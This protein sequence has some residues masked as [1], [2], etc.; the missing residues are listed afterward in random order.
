MFNIVKKSIEWNGKKIE[1]ETGKIARQASASVIVRMGESTVLCTVTFSKNLKEGIDFFPLSVNYLEKYYAAG[2]FPGGFMKREGK[3]SDRE[4][5][6]SRLIDRPIRPLFPEDFLY[7][8]NVICKVLSYDGNS[9]TDILAIIGSA[10]ALKISEVPFDNLLAA[11]RVGLID[12]KFVLNP[13]TQELEKSELDLVIAGTND[14]VLMIESSAKEIDE[15]KLISAIEIAHKNIQPVIKLIDEFAT[16]SKKDKYAYAK[17]DIQTIF[18]EL[19]KDYHEDIKKVY[20]IVDKSVRKEKLDAIYKEAFDNHSTKEG[21]ELN[22]F[23]LAYK[24]L[25]REVVR[26]KILDNNIRIDGR[27]SEEIRKIDCEIGLLPQTHGSSLFT[28]GETQSLSIVTLGSQQDSQL[29]DDVTGTYNERF[30]LH[31]NFPPYSVGEV[32]MLKP[33]GR[34][35]IG[36][37]KLAFKAVS[38]ILPK[39]EEFP[40]T[41]RIV[42][43]I[44]ESN[45]SSSMATVCAATLALMDAGVPIK[46]PV[47][48]IA[49]GLILEK[50]RHAILSDIIGDEDALGDM[51][52]KV[53]STK[54]GI[55]A[56]Q[57][58]IKI[59]GITIEIMKK[60][61]SQA[62]DGCNHILSK[63]NEL[64]SMPKDELNSSAPRISSI[65]INKDKI[66]DLIGPGGKNIKEICE[67]TGVK[68]DIEDDGSVKIFATDEKTLNE[69]LSSIEE[70]VAVP[71]IG[72]IYNAKITKIM[73]FG[74][75]AKFLGSNEGLVHVSEISDR[76][77]ENVDDVLSEGM[78]INV[79]YVGTDHKGKVKLTMK[80]VEQSDEFFN[81]DSWKRLMEGEP[82]KQ[83]PEKKFDQE[84]TRKKRVMPKQNYNKASNFNKATH[85]DK[86]KKEEKNPTLFN[87]KSFIKKLF[88]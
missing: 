38:P 77:I 54:N 44:T 8:V 15:E 66:R 53:A 42:S 28:R 2:R 27:N 35:E 46:T 22:V 56:L 71:E 87:A 84:F 86:D 7:E 17:L 33:P 18:E 9:P 48:G 32:G 29:R 52:F 79:K 47:A 74:A 19:K 73:Q 34:R 23:D 14:S 75:F 49:M 3:P 20:E 57:M 60:A 70:I 88:N 55:T 63:M 37:G 45:G 64:I 24:K 80:N 10:A 6:I 11:V 82:K 69:A 83:R 43:E 13:S 62:K 30:M 31:Y 41:I 26:D 68:I 65:K 61:I 50:D 5:L 16:D 67:R 25:R 85:H 40:Y 59:T 72:K 36:H 39:D 58:D 12:D 81:S 21:F 76:N 51:D 4:T 1:L 78:I